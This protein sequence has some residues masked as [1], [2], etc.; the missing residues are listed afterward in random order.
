MPNARWGFGKID[1][2]RAVQ[3][4][5]RRR[6]DNVA[7]PH[8][9]TSTVAGNNVTLSWTAPDTDLPVIGYTI[10]AGSQPGMANLV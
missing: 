9:F 1:A 4:V 10:K 6:G 7:G 3:E 2:Y 5:I 8:N